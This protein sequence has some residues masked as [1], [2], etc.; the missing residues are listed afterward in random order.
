M[1]SSISHVGI[2]V[3]IHNYHPR[4]AAFRQTMKA[5]QDDD[6]DG[7]ADDGDDEPMVR[8]SYDDCIR[9]TFYL[10]LVFEHHIYS[11][12]NIVLHRI[13]VRARSMCGTETTTAM[14]MNRRTCQLGRRTMRRTKNIDIR[15]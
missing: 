10:L 8:L 14:R 12:L 13:R 3:S 1:L 2:I 6:G 7:G 4:V 15:V 9:R 5:G 11:F